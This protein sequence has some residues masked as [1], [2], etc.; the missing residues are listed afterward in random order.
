MCP[1]VSGF[2]PSYTSITPEIC[3]GSIPTQVPKFWGLLYAGVTVTVT[4]GPVELPTP[5]EPGGGELEEAYNY[6]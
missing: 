6:K 4:T 1:L 3:V 2:T 5:W